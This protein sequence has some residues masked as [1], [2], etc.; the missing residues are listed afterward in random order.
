MHKEWQMEFKE[1]QLH[2][3]LQAGIEKA[4]FT[5]L[6]NVQEET[7]KQT[8]AGRDVLVQ[9]QTGTGKTA[10]FLISIFQLLLENK[11]F[12]GRK[13]LIVAPTRELADQIEK[14]AKLLG[15]FL[16]F[17]IASF[18]GG[19]GY[20]PQERAIRDGV[21]LIIGT[22]G[23]LL[24]LN[25]QGKLLFTD[26]RFLVIDEADR[27]FDMG[28]LPD[29]RRIL[30]RMPKREERITMLFSATLGLKVSQLAWEYMNEPAEIAIQP[31]HIT[32]DEITQELYHV[33]RTEK[34]S[35]LLG[36]LRKENPESV[37]IFTNT[38][39]TA[40]EISKRLEMN[41]YVNQFIIGDLPQKKRLAVIESIKAGNLKA[42]VATDVAARGLHIDD[43]T[44]VVN[45]DLPEDPENYVHRIGRTARAGKTG[46][47]I[48]LADET[49]VFGLESIEKFI[50]RKIPVVWAG[51]DL[52]A[53]DV[54]KGVRVMH[55]LRTSEPGPRRGGTGSDRP[56]TGSPAARRAKRAP[57]S[58]ERELRPE[59]VESGTGS[60]GEKPR[61]QENRP[62]R[63]NSAPGGASR[64]RQT[65]RGVP[66]KGGTADK[67]RAAS[68][69]PIEDRVAYYREKYGD[70]FSASGT[71]AA[72]SH[73]TGGTSQNKGTGK[74]GHRKNR[75]PSGGNAYAGAAPTG[76][77]AEGKLTE[78]KRTSV[79]GAHHG[80]PV[81]EKSAQPGA[82]RDAAIPTER[83]S[84]GETTPGK[85]T[86][87]GFF[88]KIIGLFT[89]RNGEK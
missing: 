38:K 23:R 78:D 76:K 87:Q 58:Y 43:L 55:R 2:P 88:R 45:Y 84:S 13:A 46:K 24:D 41:G 64:D 6:T 36:L 8:L 81:R 89:G 71:A 51:D 68:D 19:V 7:F 15:A 26:V 72:S 9:S 35:L 47:A 62:P 73:G 42:L 14:E 44:L 60:G 27:M 33:A 79:R 30:R 28:F 21:D 11:D 75:N 61:R 22:P 67:G 25:Q 80:K 66:K 54:S 57:V 48:S 86:A 17:R 32:V 77:S 20:G 5:E 50:D 49:F 31:E 69:M 83:K 74:S 82:P 52:Y 56:R 63:G 34:F 65:G 40:V 4:G 1:L 18:F 37:L 53:E 3:D 16:P 59:T 70:N 39:R 29:L 12:K 10:A 85:G